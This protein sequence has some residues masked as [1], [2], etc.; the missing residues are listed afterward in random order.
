[1]VANGEIGEQEYLAKL[2]AFV[3]KLTDSVKM[4]RNQA[5]L[6]PAFSAVDGYYK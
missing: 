1:M 6:T 2:E 5:S 3:R 4:V